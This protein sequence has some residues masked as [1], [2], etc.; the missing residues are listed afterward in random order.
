MQK[1]VIYITFLLLCSSLWMNAQHHY[2]RQYSLEQGL[3]QSEVNDIAEDQFGYLWLGTNGGGLCRFNGVGFEVFTKKDGLLENVIMGLH[4]DNNYNLWIASQKGITRYDGIRYTHLIQS[5]TTLF[6]E[7]VQ[8]LE[9]IDGAIWALARD[10]SGIRKIYGI[11]NDSI[12]NY[13][14]RYPEVFKGNRIF[15]VSKGGPRLLYVSTSAGLYAIDQR[16]LRKVSSVGNYP[17]NNQFVV[18][19]L[20]DKFRNEW[21]LVVDDDKSIDLLKVSFTGEVQKVNWPEGIPLDRIFNVY[22]DRSGGVWIAVANNGVVLLKNDEVKVFNKDNGMKASLV[23][24]FIED[25]EGNMWIG[26]SGSGLLKYGGD[27]FVSLNMHSGLGGDIVRALFQ[28]SKGNIYLGDDN[29][30]ISR[31]DGNRVKQIQASS[32]VDMGQARK[33]LELPNHN[34]L[35]AT[36]KGLFEYD[37]ATMKDVSLLYGVNSESPVIDLLKD[38][39][40]IWIAVYG[41]GL[42]K[43]EASNMKWYTPKN[44]GLTSGFIT[45]IFKDTKGKMW[46][47]TTNGVF[48]FHDEAFVHYSDKDSFHASWVLQAAED[49]VGNIWFATFTGGLSRFDGHDFTFYD[50]SN[51]IASDNIYSVIADAQ[52]NIWAG[53][54]NGVDKIDIGGGGDILS[55]VNFDKYDGFV[56]IENNGSCNLLDN[57]GRIWFGTINGAMIYNPEEEKSNYLEPPVVIRKTLLNFKEPD[58]KKEV[59]SFKYDS[60]SPWFSLPL[61]LKL[62]HDRNHVAFEFDGLCYTV[63]EKVRYKWKLEPIEQEWSPENTSYKAFYPALQPGKYTFRVIACNNDGIWNEEGASYSFEIVPAWYQYTMVRILFLMLVVAL[64]VF[65]IRQR[66]QKEKSLKEELEFHLVVK[67][68]EIQKHQTEILKQTKILK[69]QKYQLQLQAESLQSSYSNL[70]R[71]SKIGQMVTAN[72]SVDNIVELLYQS[73]SKVMSSDVFSLGLFNKEEKA[74]DFANVYVKGERQP[75]IRFLIEDKE[76]LAIYTFTHNREVFLNDFYNEYQDYI[77]ELRPVPQGAESQSVIYLPLR[78]SNEVIGVLSVQS[79]K[80]DAYTNYHLNFMQNMAIYAAIALGNAM[81]YQDLVH[82]QNVLKNQHMHV[83]GEKDEIISQKELLE[84]INYE[85]NQLL[86]LFVKGIQ[87][88]L[89]LAIGQMDGF[90]KESENCTEQQKYFLYDLLKILKQ[91]NEVINKVLEVHNIDME[92]YDYEPQPLELRDTI[93][94]VIDNLKQEAEIKKIALKFNGKQTIVNLDLS[95]FVKI[96]ENLLSNAIKFSPKEKEIRIILSSLNDKVH[97]EVHDQGPGLTKEEQNVIFKKYSKLN[98]ESDQGKASSGLGL[99]IV[100]KYVA[101]MNGTVRCES[102]S[103]FGATFIVEFPLT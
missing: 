32:Q 76:R 75:F 19:V 96:M 20:Q 102:L 42:L 65:L 30:I 17:L 86:S 21:M 72:L 27:R 64:I 45:N 8:F 10:V 66:L 34:I 31:F 69:E 41:V 44:S 89:N 95:L 25:R 88:P 49:K 1:I 6:Q 99:Y 61:G 84:D 85:K 62:S 54:Q 18:P 55:I 70:E 77:K 7:R 53:T 2:F 103:G 79:L 43:Y 98:K 39:N 37:G 80:K 23:T 57:K 38:K 91:Q 22:E 82:Q 24:C 78:S 13:Y 4:S 15:F 100:K 36:L 29:N 68:K 52:G 63:P 51:G 58:W 28:D 71:L 9:T 3:P 26:T 35:I 59:N 67:K 47:C 73:V 14:D 16:V 12:I 5:D 83:L 101:K 93:L 94:S 90:V 97:I 50:T 81:K 56:G 11:F 40:T 74:I 60:I 48:M 87:E 92:F 33:M 46:I